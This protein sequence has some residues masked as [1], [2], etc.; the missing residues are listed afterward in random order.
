MLT[1]R[2]VSELASQ[3]QDR[4]LGWLEK[5][6][7]RAHLRACEACRNFQKQMS[8]LRASV[9]KHPTIGDGEDK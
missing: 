4:P 9:R 7:L 8:F 3:S 6:R 1:C 2:Q 5:W